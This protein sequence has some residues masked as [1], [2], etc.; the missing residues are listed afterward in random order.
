M[1]AFLVD[2]RGHDV[3]LARSRSLAL[4]LKR[5]VRSTPLRHAMGQDEPAPID[6]GWGI[7]HGD[8][9]LAI[10]VRAITDVS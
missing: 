9:G 10:L 8:Y 4:F 2:S 1:H 7:A 3:H 5:S 6:G